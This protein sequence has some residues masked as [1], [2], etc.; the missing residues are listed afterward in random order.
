MAEKIYQIKTKQREKNDHQAASAA[1][2]TLGGLWLGIG[3][4][5]RAFIFDVANS[6][7]GQRCTGV[8]PPRGRPAH[9]KTAN[10]HRSSNAMFAEVDPKWAETHRFSE[11]QAQGVHL[12]SEQYWNQY[13]A[14]TCACKDCKAIVNCLSIFPIADADPLLHLITA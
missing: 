2:A 10:A 4:A 7:S 1:M 14:P 3:R 11:I 8:T 6:S 13:G 9:A 5:T 12:I